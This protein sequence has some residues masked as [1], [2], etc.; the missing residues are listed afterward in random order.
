VNVGAEVVDQI[1][2]IA[3]TARHADVTVETGLA[4]LAGGVLVAPPTP[5]AVRLLVAEPELALFFGDLS[6]EFGHPVADLGDPRVLLATD[7]PR[8]RP[9][10]V[11]L[12]F[13]DVGREVVELVAE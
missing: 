6:Q 10:R 12:S 1:V 11:A 8:R 3:V 4:I 13:D 2:G 5:L 9:L 7:Q